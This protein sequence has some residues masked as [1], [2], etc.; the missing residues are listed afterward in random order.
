MKV[1]KKNQNTQ[2]KKLCKDSVSIAFSFL[3]DD[4]VLGYF[5][6]TLSFY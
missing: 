2:N 3:K 1:E 5:T 4:V 6:V